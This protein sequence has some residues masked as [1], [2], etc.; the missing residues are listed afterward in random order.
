MIQIV[1]YDSQTFVNPAEDDRQLTV[2][3]CFFVHRDK[4]VDVTMVVRLQCYIKEYVMDSILK[5]LHGILTE[6]I[7]MVIG[8][9]DIFVFE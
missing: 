6:C 1:Y 8:Y 9:L 3:L 7:Q 4:V 5:Q 2:V